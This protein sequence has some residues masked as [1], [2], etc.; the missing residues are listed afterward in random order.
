MLLFQAI[1]EQLETEEQIKTA[2]QIFSNYRNAMFQIAYHI[3]K[4]THDAEEAVSDTIMKVCRHIDD[5]TAISGYEQKLLV[6]KYTE[7]TSID[8]WRELKRSETEEFSEYIFDTADSEG[9]TFGYE[10]DITFSGEE[11]G[12]L[13][14]HMMEI[15]KKY[16]DILVLRYVNDL[17]NKE[18]AE[19]MKIPESTV[20]THI[21]RAKQLLKKRLEEERGELY[22]KVKR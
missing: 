10:E 8:K 3:L 5:F 22:G 15:P 19:L 14:R 12:E 6:K 16:R 2:E 17:K 11:F 21:S 9:D 7:R 13:Q 4:N 18:I 20:A 1:V